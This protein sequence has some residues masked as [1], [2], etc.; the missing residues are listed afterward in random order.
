MCT[1]NR[2]RDRGDKSSEGPREGNYD[3]RTES[4]GQLRRFITIETLG[5][6][7][8]FTRRSGRR[9]P[10]SH[11]PRPSRKSG[12]K[13]EI[14]SGNHL[15]QI[16]SGLWVASSGRRWLST[17]LVCR[18]KCVI[19][20]TMSQGVLLVRTSQSHPMGNMDLGPFLLLVFL[21]VWMWSGPR[22][23]KYF[24]FTNIIMK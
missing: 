10:P 15:P 14:L 9:P 22:E 16:A 11:R 1:R 4:T 12:R 13:G 19:R 24:C 7:F 18:V 20:F 5:D 6:I 3:L 17:G 2:E 23:W 8:M 21:G